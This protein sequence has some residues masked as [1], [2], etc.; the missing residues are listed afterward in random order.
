MVTGVNG[1]VGWELN[2]RGARH[3][4]KVLGLD[5]AELDITNSS[6]VDEVIHRDEI[7]LVVNAAAYTNVDRAESESELALL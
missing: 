7:S 2:R 3:G 6:S 5:H 4:F 1:Q